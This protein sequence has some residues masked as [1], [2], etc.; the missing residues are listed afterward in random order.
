MNT[1]SLFLLLGIEAVIVIAEFVCWRLFVRNAVP[2]SFP[3]DADHS[4]L[5]FFTFP[6]L[7]LIALAHALLLMGFVLSVFLFLW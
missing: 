1:S 5:R 3:H 4:S 2:I 6:R 7:R